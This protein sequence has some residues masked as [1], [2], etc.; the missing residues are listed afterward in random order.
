MKVEGCTNLLVML[1]WGTREHERNRREEAKDRDKDSEGTHD[2]FI[3]VL[4]R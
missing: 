1:C 2:L 4:H 3:V